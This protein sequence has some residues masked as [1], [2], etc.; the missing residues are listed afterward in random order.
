MCTA[1][2]HFELFQC[3]SGRNETAFILGASSLAWYATL[4]CE[5]Y[6]KSPY[7]VDN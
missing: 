2:G 7:V 6:A 3:T 5:F 1:G 4:L